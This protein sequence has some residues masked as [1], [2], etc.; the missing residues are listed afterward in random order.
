MLQNLVDKMIT[1]IPLKNLLIDPSFIKFSDRKILINSSIPAE[2]TLEL[3]EKLKKVG[4]QLLG[5]RVMEGFF[6]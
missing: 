6:Q 1:Q 4:S 3:M 2:K 5:P